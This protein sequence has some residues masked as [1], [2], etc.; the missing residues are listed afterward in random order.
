MKRL[1]L[2]RHAKSDWDTGRPDFDRPLNER[3]EAAA[4]YMAA[5]LA[6]GYARPDLLAS[7]PAVRA[8]RTAALIARGIGIQ[9][10]AIRTEASLYNASVRQLLDCVRATEDGVGHLM[11]VAH[12]PGITDL[13]NQLTGSRID[14]M[15]T[16]AVLG[17]DLEIT[18]WH[19]TRPGCGRVR[20]YDYPK[21]PSLPELRG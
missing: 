16:C 4:P 12:N 15:V 17:A 10:S 18:S 9:E 11:L 13:A 6:Q 21:N 3:G 14:E 2:I 20:Y 1:T 7:S 5:R 8:L 19:E